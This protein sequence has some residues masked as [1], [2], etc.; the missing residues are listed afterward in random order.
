M[1]IIILISNIRCKLLQKEKADKFFYKL[2][3]LFD[4]K[5]FKMTVFYDPT[6]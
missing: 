2:K 3:E 6:Q 4:P 5:V 1:T